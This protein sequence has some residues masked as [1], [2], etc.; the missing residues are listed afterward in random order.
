MMRNF[1]WCMGSYCSSGEVFYPYYN[2]FRPA[3][4]YYARIWSLW[5]HAISSQIRLQLWM[6]RSHQ[7]KISDT[8]H[9]IYGW[10]APTWAEQ[11]FTCQQ[12]YIRVNYSV[13]AELLMCVK[14]DNCLVLL[15][16]LTHFSFIISFWMF[17]WLIYLYTGWFGWRL[18]DG[19][20]LSL[21]IFFHLLIGNSY[22]WKVSKSFH[23]FITL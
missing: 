8:K 18:H 1:R 12:F 5:K 23:F 17:C 4:S 14:E 9:F 19:N 21:M 2:R 13:S 7:L 10:R 16:L 6:K 11:T 20:C 22:I 3:L 15:L